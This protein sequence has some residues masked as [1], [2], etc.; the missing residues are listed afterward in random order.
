M[1]V[2]NTTSPVVGLKSPKAFP[3]KV[4]PSWSSSNAPLDSIRE[5]E[6]G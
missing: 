1:P 6:M 3:E 4:V 5:Q 2:L